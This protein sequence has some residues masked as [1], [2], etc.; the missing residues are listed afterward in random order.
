ML[1]HMGM[2]AEVLGWDGGGSRLELRRH[3]RPG[4]LIRYPRSARLFLLASTARPDSRMTHA[5]KK[6]GCLLSAF[7]HFLLP[8][9]RCGN[10][11]RAS[12]PAP[13]DKSTSCR[14]AWLVSQCLGWLLPPGQQNLQLGFPGQSKRRAVAV[15]C[16]KR[17]FGRRKTGPTTSPNGYWGPS[18]QKLHDRRTTSCPLD[19]RNRNG[20]DLASVGM[21]AAGQGSRGM[22]DGG[23]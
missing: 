9:R 11:D 2:F 20:W 7:L 12:R 5:P 4:A 22:G 19:P 23:W 8:V 10:Q 16:R 17:V 13:N 14:H 3:L 18:R 21:G 1:R 15:S 6:Q